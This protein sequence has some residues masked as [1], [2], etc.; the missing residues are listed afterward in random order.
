MKLQLKIMLIISGLIIFII[1]LLYYVFSYHINKN[2]EAQMGTSAMDFAKTVASLD[3]V[4]TGL[5]N[6]IDYTQMNTFIEAIRVE[7]SY[8]YIIVMDMEGIQYSYPYEVGIGKPYKNGGESKVLELGEA[9]VSADRNVLVSAIRSFVPI[10]YDKEQVGAVLV[11]LLTDRVQKETEAN[12]RNL[13]T[14]VVGG[15]FL[16][17]FAAWILTTNIKKSIFGLEPKEIA[18][19]LGERELVFNT[20][21]KS[22]ISIDAKGKI[23]I[24]NKSAASILSLTDKAQG[25]DFADYHPKLANIFLSTI[26]AE[27]NQYNQQIILENQHLM[28]NSCLMHG[29]NNE[30][31]GLVANIEL[32]TDAIALAYELTGYKEMIET[33]RATNH[34]FMNKLHTIGG[35]IQLEN[36]EEALDYIDILSVRSKEIQQCLSEKIGSKRLSGLLLGKYNR[37]VEYNIRFNLKPESYVANQTLLIQEEVIATILGNLIE[38][39]FDVLV[40]DA[41]SR[42]GQCSVFIYADESSVVIEVF[43]NGPE[44]TDEM[45]QQIFIKGYSTKRN[46]DQS[47]GQGLYIVKHLV[48]QGNGTISFENIKGVKWH[49]EFKKN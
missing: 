23:L 40:Q 44:I 14:A 8:Q 1:G 45:A 12:R 33:L 19:L 2:I 46:N 15:F 32:M 42:H 39:S 20:I 34:E 36:Y 16:S 27:I 26:E 7:T 48:E 17:V 10:Y 25:H 47:H 35:L 21:E 41:M 6:K 37:F 31:V 28:I 4:K 18:I 30:I 5:K 49:V 29:P 11:G 38:N 22:L 13:E 3:Y 43:N 9:Y 24:Y